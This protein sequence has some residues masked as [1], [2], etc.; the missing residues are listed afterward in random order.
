MGFRIPERR[1]RLGRGVRSFLTVTVAAVAAEVVRR[2]ARRGMRERRGMTEENKRIVRRALEEVFSAGR[3]ELVDEL[4]APD[5]IGHDVARPEP[6]RGR[7]G[8]RQVVLGYRSAFPDLSLMADQQL[9][10]RDSVCTLWTARGTHQG[11]LFGIPPTNR[12]ATVTGIT[13]D[14][15]RDGRIVESTT[16]WDALGLMQQLGVVSLPAAAPAEA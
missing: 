14:R 10:E 13:I 7:E 15:L 12:Q 2:L 5:W 6:S 4:F 9:A 3:L 1:K 16:N 11:E 8:A